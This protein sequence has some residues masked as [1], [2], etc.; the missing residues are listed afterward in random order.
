[1]LGTKE[2]VRMNLF[3]TDVND[4]GTVF[5]VSALNGAFFKGPG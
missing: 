1:V 4:E 2:E 3:N 5:N